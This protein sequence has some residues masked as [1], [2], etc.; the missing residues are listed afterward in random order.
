MTWRGN[1]SK[2]GEYIR[3]ETGLPFTF[4]PFCADCG[5]EQVFGQGLS[6]ANTRCETVLVSMSPP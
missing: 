4:L 6:E 5:A 3:I 2:D 1:G